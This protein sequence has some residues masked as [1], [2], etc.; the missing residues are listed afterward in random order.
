MPVHVDPGYLDVEFDKDPRFVFG[1]TGDPKSKS[2]ASP[3]FSDSIPVMTRSQIE[4]EIER[5]DDQK[6]GLEYA[7]TRIHD[8]DGVGQCVTDAT[9][10]A[11]ESQQC[12]QFGPSRVIFLSACSLYNRRL[13]SR[14]NSGSSISDALHELT[15]G[16]GMLPLNTPENEKLF[17]GMTMPNYGWS[18]QR[19][20]G[21]ETVGRE[22]KFGEH[23]TL[24]TIDEVLTAGILGFNVVVGRRGHSICYTRPTKDQ[25]GNIVMPYPNSWR[26]DWGQPYGNMSGGFGFDSM[27]L[28][29]SASN[30]CWAVR[31]AIVPKNIQIPSPA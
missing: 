27:S 22:F 11:H 7:V 25:R 6:T 10:Q 14:P 18:L 23:Y 16:D 26:L 30:W 1:Y 28:I 2:A 9:G 15:V 29:G 17:P 3:S 24:D 13:G 19:P 21:W 4:A 12:L 31:T 8:Q 20:Q 5:L